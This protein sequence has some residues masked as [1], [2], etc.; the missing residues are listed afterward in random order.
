MSDVTHVENT[1]NPTAKLTVLQRNADKSAWGKL[2]PRSGEIVKA[3]AEL[4]NGQTM[5]VYQMKYGTEAHRGLRF[6][7]LEPLPTTGK[8]AVASETFSEQPE[9][10]QSR[11]GVSGTTP[12]PCAPAPLPPT[13]VAPVP[14]PVLW[15]D[16]EM[17][18][19]RSLTNILTG[20][21]PYRCHKHGWTTDHPKYSVRMACGCALFPNLE[22]Q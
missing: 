12:N 16:A 6:V 19:F 4:P 22:R 7:T 8:L 10:I 3:V 14:R 20:Q 5:V 2:A 21:V 9:P 15:T 18:I 1:E 17:T 11:K 13:P